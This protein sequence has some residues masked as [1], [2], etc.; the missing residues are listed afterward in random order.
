MYAFTETMINSGSTVNFK[1]SST[2][3]FSSA[4]QSVIIMSLI[5]QTVCQ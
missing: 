3:E 4:N 5:L 2:D 1:D